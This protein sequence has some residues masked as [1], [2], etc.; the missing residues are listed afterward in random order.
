MSPTESEIAAGAWAELCLI[1]NLH[2]SPGFPFLYVI[3]KDVKNKKEGPS[4]A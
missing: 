3:V 1:P 4:S 2:S